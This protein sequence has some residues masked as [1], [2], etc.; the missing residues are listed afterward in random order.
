MK[1]YYE[2]D[3]EFLNDI[4]E[5][6][7]NALSAKNINEIKEWPCADYCHHGLGM[8]IRNHY[9]LWEICDSDPIAQGKLFLNPDYF[10][11]LA[12]EKI[13]AA[14]LPEENFGDESRFK[15]RLYSDNEF[16]EIRKKYFKE[17]K[18]NDL[19]EVAKK[20]QN[21]LE[22]EEIVLVYDEDLGR[23]DEDIEVTIR[24]HKIMDE[25]IKNLVKKLKDSLEK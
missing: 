3:E 7:L 17:N 1:D 21:S 16:L 11:Y 9:N 8:Y 20:Y 2:S 22:L 14:L 25:Q 23:M 24:N 5:D 12:V 4:V 13:I 19:I 15:E 18:I 6:C 10:S